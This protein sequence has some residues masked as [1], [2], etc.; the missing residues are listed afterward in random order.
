M[1]Y[2]ALCLE[3]SLTTSENIKLNPGRYLLHMVH[4]LDNK[5]SAEAI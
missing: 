2:C 1:K 5:H 3:I 4:E